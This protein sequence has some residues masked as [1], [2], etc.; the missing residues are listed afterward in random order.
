[1]TEREKSKNGIDIP[2]EVERIISELDE[3]GF[4]AY[5]VGGCVRD[6]LLGKKPRDWDVATNA[7]PEK[8]RELF[9]ESFYENKFFTV[10]V[11]TESEDE[12]LR[13]IEV[14]TFR[15]EGRYEDKRHPAEIKPAKTIEEDLARRDFTVNAIAIALTS[16][17]L[18]ATSYQLFDPFGGQQDLEKKLIRAVGKPEERFGED[19][20]RMLR[21]V[22][23][24]A[25]LEFEIEKETEEAIVKNS[26]WLAAIS[27]ERIREEFSKILMTKNAWSG[28]ELLHK[29]A[30]LKHIMPELEEGIGCGQ[31]KHHIY[32]VWEHNLRALDYAAKQNWP[33][34]VRM[35]ALLHDVAKP[36]AKAGDGPDSTFYGHDVVGAKISAQILSR[37]RYSDDFIQKIVKLVRWHL[38][39][40]DYEVDEVQTTDSSIRRL[41]KNVGVE[42]IE[43]LVKVRMC[44]RI[45]SGVP[46]AVP[47]RLRHFQFRV[48]KILRE[49]E[50]V[51][52]TMLKVGGEDVMR[53]LGIAPGPKVGHVLNALLEEVLDDPKKNER[54]Y[55][56]SRVSELGKL[57]DK[58]LVE[59]REKA[60]S[61]VELL[62]GQ[63]EE[64]IKK[65]YY[66][67]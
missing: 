55:L 19:A 23:L 36:R 43:D 3:A 41:I 16:Y 48:E 60:E 54:E 30:L 38:F 18:Q 67:K 42:N 10:T 7:M 59:L 2:A 49:H 37:L 1:M 21:A 26:G 50:A 4:E 66:V 9:P 63:R 15:A 53:I 52:V 6:I 13:E 65:K 22:R 61:K 33:L 35:G 46:K 17:Q 28:I 39:R 12:T 47:Y 31:N 25:E 44:D 24:A 62:E 57:S 11:K 40:Y 51:K 56:E 27:K 5:A 64:E 45:G 8:I 20:L 14:T 29:A 32:P 58:E 34:A